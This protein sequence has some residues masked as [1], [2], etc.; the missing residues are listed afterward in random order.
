M[1]LSNRIVVS[2]IALL[3]AGLT[4]IGIVNFT[5]ACRLQGAT[6]NGDPLEG[7]SHKLGLSETRSIVH[8]PV[9]SLAHSILA[10]DDV[11]KVDIAYSLPHKLDIRTNEFDPLCFVVG[12][13]TGKLFGLNHEGRLVKLNSAH[14]DW[15]RPV[16]TNVV[17]GDLFSTCNDSRIRVVIEQLEA[18]RQEKI[19]VYRLI[20]GVDFS[21]YRFLQVLVSGLPYHLRLRAQKL[22]NDMQRFIDFVLLYDV[23][24]TNVKCIDLRYDDMIICAQGS[25]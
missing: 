15:E 2:S 10:R 11:F 21:D 16:F 25:K 20:D 6:L 5:D 3:T 7:W 1:D 8:Q 17:T 22:S 14:L 18:L 4:L 9:D 13:T 12:K 23:D 24:L 19:D